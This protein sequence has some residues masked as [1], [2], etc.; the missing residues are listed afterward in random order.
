V[1]IIP[2]TSRETGSGSMASNT[3][4]SLVVGALSVVSLSGFAAAGGKAKFG[5]WEMM[6]QPPAGET[7][8]ERC[9]KFTEQHAI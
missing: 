9:A 3:F 6:C 7:A 4:K 5:A 8:T 1:A 2:Q